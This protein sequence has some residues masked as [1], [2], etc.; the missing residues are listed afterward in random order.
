MERVIAYQVN[1]EQLVS[2]K[3]K[4]MSCMQRCSHDKA[5][6]AYYNYLDYL[7]KKRR[8]DTQQNDTQHKRLICDTP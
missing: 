4:F 8:H 2:L 5:L 7:R 3:A 1:E 6:L